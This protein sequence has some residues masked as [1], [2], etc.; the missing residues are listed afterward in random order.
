MG[1][2]AV[3]P[4]LVDSELFGFVLL[5]HREATGPG[6]PCDPV[7]VTAVADRLALAMARLPELQRP[8]DPRASW[9]MSLRLGLT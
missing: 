8:R 3:F 6:F 9:R 4:L 2:I 5:G 1:A 7:R